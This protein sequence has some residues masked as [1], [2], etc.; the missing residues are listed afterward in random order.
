[1]QDIMIKKTIYFNLF[2]LLGFVFLKGQDQYVKFDFTVN[3]EFTNKD[4]I[5]KIYREDKIYFSKGIE[6]LGVVNKFIF[7]S[8]KMNGKKTIDSESLKKIKYTKIKDLDE[9]SNIY[10][11][12]ITKENNEYYL[13]PVEW[14]ICHYK[15]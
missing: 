4:F 9:N 7:D 6:T 2:F 5:D 8:S 15:E 12:E 10:I 13:Y 11:V 3:N 14:I 1:M